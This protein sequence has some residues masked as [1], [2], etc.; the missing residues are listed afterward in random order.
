MSATLAARRLQLKMSGAGD[1]HLD[2]AVDAAT[3]QLSGPGNL[4][5]HGLVAGH[6]DVSVRGPGE[7]VLNVKSKGAER[8]RQM[9]FDRSGTRVAGE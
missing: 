7:A 9:T 8:L 6:A 3:A 2:G 1:V 5:A 4:D